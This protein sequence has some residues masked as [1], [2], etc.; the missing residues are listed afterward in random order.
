MVVENSE[1]VPRGAIDLP[2]VRD[3]SAEHV[4]GAAD[5]PLPEEVFLHLEEGSQGNSVMCTCFSAYH[6]A[7]IANEAEH[8]TLLTPDFIKG[9]SLQGEFGT[10]TKDGDYVQTALK[11]L[12]KNGLHTLTGNKPI[13]GYATIEKTYESIQ[14][15]L[16]RGYAVVTSMRVTNT[17]FKK[18]KNEGVW[19]GMDGGV[20]GG[21]AVTISGYKED[22]LI[23]SN[24]YGANWGYFRNGTFKVKR[25][26]VP[27]L[28]TCY[29]VYDKKD[30]EYLY[31]DVTNESPH[32]E[33][34]KKMK[35]LGIMTGYE[36]GRFGPNN[37]VTRSELA[38]VLT[39]FINLTK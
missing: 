1:E 21:H 5:I 9:W 32:F 26:D 2:D 17:N 39:R 37:P 20:V 6:A 4:L 22:H 24:S 13:L 18:A 29:V 34:I 23:V 25:Q 14:Y 11:S 36:D 19:G 27:A 15:W 38:A 35:E 28:G 33:A 3:Y 8:G 12:V 30:A 16:A 10:R 7:Q 31:K